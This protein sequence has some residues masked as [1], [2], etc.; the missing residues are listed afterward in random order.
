MFKCSFELIVEK[1][2]TGKSRITSQQ[3]LLYCLGFCIAPVMHWFAIPQ[4]YFHLNSNV[5]EQPHQTLQ[6]EFSLWNILTVRQGDASCKDNL[7]GYSQ[8]LVQGDRS[9]CGSSSDNADK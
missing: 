4:S 8:K 1:N 3:S 7:Q 9:P 5:N 2:G 6:Y